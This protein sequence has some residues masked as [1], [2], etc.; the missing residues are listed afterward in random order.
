MSGI[1]LEG[2][3]APG[4]CKDLPWRFV[5]V[6][7]ILEHRLSLHK[8][9]CPHCPLPPPL[10]RSHSRERLMGSAPPFDSSQVHPAMTIATGFL[11]L[12]YKKFPRGV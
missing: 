1:K 4:Y 6:G 10:L 5:H 12:Q 9:A 7:A 8:T 2:R 3:L 11:V